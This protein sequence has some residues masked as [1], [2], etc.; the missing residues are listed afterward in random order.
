MTLKASLLNMP[1][2]QKEEF[3]VNPSNQQ[4]YR[5]AEGVYPI[6]LVELNEDVNLR[7]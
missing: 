7:F 5:G 3:N 1:R 2:Y 4:P 6:I